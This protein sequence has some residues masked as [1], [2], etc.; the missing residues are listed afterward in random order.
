MVFILVALLVGA[1]IRHMRM[2]AMLPDRTAS[3]SGS[4]Y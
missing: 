4:T 1:G 3:Y 2:N